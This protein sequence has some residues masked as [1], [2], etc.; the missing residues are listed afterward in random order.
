MQKL[1]PLSEDLD[2]ILDSTLDLWEEVRNK[3]LF[4]TGGTG[5]FGC[6]LLESFLWANEKLD[7]QASATIL[8]RNFEAF[9]KKAP[10]LAFNPAVNF[11]IGDVCSFDFPNQKFDFVIQAA[12]DVYQAIPPAQKIETIILGTKR[13]LEFAKFCQAKKILLSSSGA[14]YGKQPATLSHISEEYSGAP[15][16]TDPN[17]AYGEAKRVAELLCVIY[18]TE[19]DFEIKIARCFAFVGAYL[20]LDGHL[21][22]G[23]FIKDCLD[24]EAIQI[25]SD[26]TPIR[27]YMYASDLTVWLWTILFRGKSCYPYNVG[28]ENEISL[29]KLAKM[30]SKFS[31]KETKIEIAQNPKSNHSLPARY[32]PQTQRACLELGLQCSV[33]LETAIKKTLQFFGNI[34]NGN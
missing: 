25:N 17:S 12:T 13:V 8:T 32:V 10:H 20:Q 11:E 6:W 15:D 21:A 33:N 16:L 22:I 31:V 7:L 24:G 18:A 23:N 27:S 28:S 26:G 4:I 29:A 1:N 2:F 34:K 3:R 19:N 9:E 30:I 14:V 5:F